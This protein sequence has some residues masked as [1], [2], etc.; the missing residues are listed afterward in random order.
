MQKI[1]PFLWFDGNA[2]AAAEFY[3]SIFKHSKIV[4]LTRYPEA[5]QAVHG[6]LPGT[7]MTVTF[8]LE[9]QSFTALN[10][11][12]IFAFNQAVSFVVDCADQDEIDYYW[13]R[14]G[15]GSNAQAQQY[16]WL[17]DRYG[18]WWQIVP[19]KLAEL[20]ADPIADK[21]NRVMQAI[22]QMK[23]I[24]IAGLQRAFETE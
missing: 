2:E 19:R 12:P 3:V 24:D 8:E 1:T 13:S 4:S 23:K 17:K 16:G 14:L 15:E 20:L 10:G 5:G 18:L 21:R 7:V 22:L 11:G 9:G 6:Q